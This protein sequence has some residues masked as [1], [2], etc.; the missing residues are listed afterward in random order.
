[1]LRYNHLIIIYKKN[2]KASYPLIWSITKNKRLIEH[3]SFYIFSSL[4]VYN[5]N[6]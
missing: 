6:V 1:M 3:L 2:L 4:I 5:L